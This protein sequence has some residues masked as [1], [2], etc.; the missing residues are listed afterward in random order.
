MRSNLFFA[1]LGIIAGSSFASGQTFKTNAPA[2]TI[3]T[4]TYWGDAWR[5][6]DFY[7]DPEPPEHIAPAKLA[8]PP[9]APTK[10]ESATPQK[11]VELVKFELL[12]KQL[13]N[14]RK[15]AYINPSERNVRSYM[16][17]EVKVVAQASYFADVAQ[18]LAWATPDLDQ[19]TIGRPVNGAA[20]EVFEHLQSRSRAQSI[21][22][23]GK[24][25]VL[26]FF[27]R[28]DCPYC[29]AFAP[30]LEAFQARFG[31]QI[32]PISVDGGTLPSFRN[33][34]RDNGISTT[35]NVTQVPATFLAQ[36]FTGKIH[37]VG[38]GVLTES[39]LLERITTITTPTSE[40]MV[41]AT[42][43]RIAIQ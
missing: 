36:P 18:R 30:I 28:G 7:E 9:I 33:P 39:Q 14:Y 37:P 1:V 8:T 3:G 6:W 23:I 42:I 35:L 2:S 19:T 17:L 13:E 12:Q 25:H 29:H 4:A 41:P 26:F 40:A 5:G 21:G 11:P 10:R 16:E 32:V 15:I 24:D 27:F 43:K 34:R 31:I 22:E 38:F 20:L